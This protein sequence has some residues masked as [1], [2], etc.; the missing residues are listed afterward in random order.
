M[1]AFLYEMNTERNVFHEMN[2]YRKMPDN[3]NQAQQYALPR[4]QT[5]TNQRITKGENNNFSNEP[6]IQKE[7][8]KAA[9]KELVSTNTIRSKPKANSPLIFT[10]PRVNDQQIKYKQISHYEE[11]EDYLL[12]ETESEINS[13]ELENQ[14]LI[15]LS[16]QTGNGTKEMEELNHSSDGDKNE[17]DSFSDGILKEENK[18]QIHLNTLQEES[19]SSYEKGSTL[20]ENLEDDFSS[21]LKESDT[22]Q[23]ESSSNQDERS[24]SNEKTTNDEDNTSLNEELVKKFTAM[25]E[26]SSSK[27]DE[28]SSSY[29]ESSSHE[30]FSSNNDDSFT[31]EKSTSSFDESSPNEE[32]S[33]H[34]DDSSSHEE[35]SSNNDDSF[36]HEKSTSSFDKSSPHEESFSHYDDSF[37]H[38]KSTSS[39][40]E[41]SPNEESSS[42]YADFSSQEGVPSQPHESS[43]SSEE[44]SLNVNESFEESSLNANESFEESSLNANESFEESS[45]LVSYLDKCKDPVQPPIVKLPVILASIKVDIDIYDSFNLEIPISSLT[46]VD[47]SIHSLECKV[48]L[49][50]PNVFLKGELIADI[51][52]VKD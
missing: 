24:F 38:E 44:S 4:R 23:E 25:L 28:S 41:S 10:P 14:F 48:L 3:Y 33:S 47:W 1:Q 35:F 52:Y 43:S 29:A 27:S 9:K 17:K 12:N 51:E 5:I 26:E 46:K 42:H 22:L 13:S 39:I 40:G 6:S 30:E 49:P 11:S 16:D 37:T 36:A 18:D 2:Y 8:Q 19:S 45:S 20:N 50:T 21:I 7:I 31:H 34:Y 15:Q 32:S